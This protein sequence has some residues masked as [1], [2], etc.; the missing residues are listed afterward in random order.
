MGQGDGSITRQGLLSLQPS[1]FG[2]GHVAGLGT[3]AAGL[4]GHPGAMPAAP[5]ME[6]EEQTG[7]G[8]TAERRVLGSGT[9]LFVEHQN[10]AN[11]PCSLQRQ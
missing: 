4:H 9:G 7:T 8:A 3:G 11:T 10:G 1:C 5:L 6:Q 2:A